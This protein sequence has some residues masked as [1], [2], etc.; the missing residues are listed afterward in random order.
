[1]VVKM[2]SLF[3]DLFIGEYVFMLT[4]V[5]VTQVNNDEHGYYENKQ[6]IKLLGYLLD[7]DDDYYYIG[8]FPDRVSQAI[9]KV[10]VV[11]VEIADATKTD[12]LL[13]EESSITIQPDG[14][15]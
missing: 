15:E 8:E 14:V 12:G 3:Y 11:H 5:D 6:P 10:N 9:K 7:M 1:M 2:K 4:T 13:L